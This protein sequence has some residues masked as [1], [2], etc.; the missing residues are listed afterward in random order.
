MT[1]I[2]PMARALSGALAFLAWQAHAQTPPQQRQQPEATLPAVVVEGHANPSLTSKTTADLKRTLEQTVGSVGFVD[3]SSYTNTYAF[4]LRDVLQDV[5]GVF[6]QN[7]YGQEL[8][9]SIRGSGIARSYHTRGL[10]ILQD[11]IPTNLAD[12][13]GDYY[14]IDP[15]ALQATRLAIRAPSESRTA[16]RSSSTPANCGSTPG[17]STRA[18][19]IRSSRCSSRTA[20]PTASHRATQVISR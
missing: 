16:P 6:V 17:R 18:S 1:N 9:V 5:P 10:E 7:R 19:I 8:R 3:S 4:T 13:S 2:A 11:G 12:G 15:L 20:G 14:Q